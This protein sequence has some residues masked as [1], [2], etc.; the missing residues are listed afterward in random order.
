MAGQYTEIPLTLPNDTA[1]SAAMLAAE[2]G[3]ATLAD[4]LA[5]RVEADVKAW[6]YH[7]G[8]EEGIPLCKDRNGR[9]APKDVFYAFPVQKTCPE[10]RT[11]SGAPR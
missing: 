8:D 7:L 3:F 6:R 2:A 9:P 1:R 5:F 4:Y 10:C 11:I